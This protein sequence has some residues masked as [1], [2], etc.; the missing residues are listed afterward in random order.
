MSVFSNSEVRRVLR[1]F[2]PV[3]LEEDFTQYHAQEDELSEFF[4]RVVRGTPNRIQNFYQKGITQGH[5]AFDATGR[6]LGGTNSR[7]NNIDD[8]TPTAPLLNMLANAKRKFDTAPPAAIDLPP[9]KQLG[10]P[11]PPEGT[12]VIQMYTRILPLPPGCLPRNARLGR[13]TLWILPH[14]I[15][16]LRG[17]R[18]ARSL[19]ARILRFSLND[20]VRSFPQLWNPEDVEYADF[21]ITSSREGGFTRFTI[22]GR[23]QMKSPYVERP[24]V[25]A[26]GNAKVYTQEPAGYE[27]RLVGEIVYDDR[28]HN[29]ADLHFLADGRAWGKKTNADGEPNGKYPLQIAFVMSS[30]PLAAEITPRAL[31]PLVRHFDGTD[32]YYN[33]VLPDHA[34]RVTVR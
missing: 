5:Y 13:D 1:D 2:I 12:T 16:E 8:P 10:R 9:W 34:L 33:P 23:F 7:S 32:G 25:D 15:D 20:N 21:E 4:W 11:R 18:A 24:W 3:A 31:G 22:D 29:L 14:E 27:G 30:D 6:S 28:K 17:G 26:A 19:W